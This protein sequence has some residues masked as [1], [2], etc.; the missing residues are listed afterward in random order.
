ML[1]RFI[2]DIYIQLEEYLDTDKFTFESILKYF[3]YLGI[4]INLLNNDYYSL[5]I[6]DFKDKIINFDNFR[7]HIFVQN[8]IKDYYFYNCQNLIS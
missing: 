2:Y 3:E 5:F 7:N 1:D 8:T 4:T 6:K